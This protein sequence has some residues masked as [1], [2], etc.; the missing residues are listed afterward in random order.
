MHDKQA[1]WVRSKCANYE[2]DNVEEAKIPVY[3]IQP[4][5]TLDKIVSNLLQKY[6]KRSY[7]G[8]NKYNTTLEDNNK[9]NYLL[10]LQQELQDGSLY[11]EKLLQQREDITQLIKQYPNDQEL[12]K[13]IR[14][15]YGN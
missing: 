9:D 2:R 4:L 8:L 15:L 13:I 5:K 14:Q 3:E 10:H 6:L 12:G 7:A 1:E 11:I